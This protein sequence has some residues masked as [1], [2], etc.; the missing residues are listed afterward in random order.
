MT[1]WLS[2]LAVVASVVCGSAA[3]DDRSILH[4]VLDSG[5][6]KVG[7]TGDFNPMSFKDPE[8]KKYRGHQIDA[9][10]QLATDMGVEVEFVATDW[11]TLINGVVAGKYDIVMTG[12]SM[13]VT[14]AKAAGYTIPWG[15]NRL[16]AADPARRS[17]TGSGRGRT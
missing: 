5:T 16:P 14:R 2:T 13:T 12:T 17:R 15:R 7:T 3:A 6:L 4:K 10:K 11:K 9:A 1:K 8:T